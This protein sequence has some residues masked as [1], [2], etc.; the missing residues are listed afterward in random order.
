MQQVE[1]GPDGARTGYVEIPGDGAPLVLLHGLGA[2]SAPYYAATVASPALAGRHALL[3]DLLGFGTSDRPRAFGYSLAEQADAVARALDALG[4]AAVDLVAHSMSGG[5]AVIL[6]DRRP[7][8][9]ARL[10][11]VEPSLRPTAR[12]GV[13]GLTEDEFVRTGFT[14]RLEA[15]GPQWA[16]TMRL[17]DPVAQYRAERALGD[18][19]V[20][21]AVLYGLPMPVHVIEGGIS[22]WLAGDQALAR[23]GIGVT[24]V[25]DTTHVLMLEAPAAFAAAVADALPL[26]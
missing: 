18:M 6:A 21:D 23:A 10:V 7:D 1:V 5:I 9:V 20:L 14:R 15:A 26:P 11:L 25:P 22:G 12:P 19:P 13:D 8:L 3:V 16:A 24:V 4:I 2:A 17:A